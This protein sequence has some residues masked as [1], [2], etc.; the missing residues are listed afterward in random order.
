MKELI[1]EI[2]NK[3]T[4]DIPSFLHLKASFFYLKEK[5][6]KKSTNNLNPVPVPPLLR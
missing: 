4:L 2:M 5:F 3:K 6:I 1:N